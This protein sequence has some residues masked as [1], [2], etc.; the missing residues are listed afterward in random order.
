MALIRSSGA[1]ANND[2]TSLSSPARAGGSG[3]HDADV[4]ERTLR[5]LT[6]DSKGISKRARESFKSSQTPVDENLLKS[7]GSITTCSWCGLEAKLRLCKR[8]KFSSYCSPECQRADWSALFVSSRKNHDRIVC[9]LCRPQ[10]KKACSSSDPV[11]NIFQLKTYHL[12]SRAFVIPNLVPFLMLLSHF[13]LALGTHPDNVK[14]Q[15]CVAM[16]DLVPVMTPPEYYH[17]RSAKERKNESGEQRYMLKLVSFEAVP[18]R[19]INKYY[20]DSRERHPSEDDDGAEHGI[21]VAPCLSKSVRSI[22]QA[23]ASVFWT[24]ILV[25]RNV[26][27]WLLN[28]PSMRALTLARGNNHKEQVLKGLNEGIILDTKNKWRLR[29]ASILYPASWATDHL[30]FSAVSEGR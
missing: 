12:A 17:K 1:S 5:L 30:W 22:G 11:N 14:T 20:L 9:T 16:W 21:I 3:L 26:D 4:F 15:T 29:T 7:V 13:S 18:T 24:N 27:M 10:H 23:V 28:S 2:T 19:T 8:C 6:A 25:P